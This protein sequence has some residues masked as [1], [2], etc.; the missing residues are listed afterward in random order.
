MKD[1]YGTLGISK[2][3]STDE[4]KSAYRKL[5]KQYH[6]DLN[7]NNKEAESKMKDINAAHDILSDPQKKANFDKFGSTEGMAGGFGG[8]RG[9]GGFE[10]FD[11]GSAFSGMGDIFGDFFGGGDPFRGRTRQRENRGNDIHVKL[12][13]SFKE[14]ALGTTKIIR[15]QRF[16][17]CHDCNGTGAEHGTSMET[18]GQCHGKG[19]VRQT[20]RLGAFGVVENVIPCSFCNASG[21]IIK[22]KCTKCSGKGAK[23]VTIEYE[24]EIPAGIDNGQT[25]S[26]PAQGDAALGS[27]GISGALLTTVR[28]TKHPILIREG[29]DLYVDIPISFTQAILGDRV[30]I[31]TVDG[32]I[33]FNVPPHT[34]N[35]YTHRIKGKGIK[36]LRSLGTGDLIVKVLVEIPTKLDKKTLQ[37]M[38]HIEDTTPEKDYPNRTAYRE[39]LRKL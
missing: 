29:F 27:E 31:P 16:E 36:R 32:F 15:F 23:K 13:L 17:K 30:R 28:V 7:P 22:D 14:A 21:K 5:A 19:R 2:G 6:P 25:L 18:C 26:Y 9:F 20:T 38:R 3:A 24:A 4:I 33:D 37:L 11:F 39:K 10:G 1:P 12:D 8:G 34:Q 35:G